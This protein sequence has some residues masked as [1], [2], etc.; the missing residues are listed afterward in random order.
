MSAE[1]ELPAGM[2]PAE[3]IAATA[4]RQALPGEAERPDPDPEAA[5][6]R[7]RLTEK[8]TVMQ[9]DLGGLFYE[10]AIRDALDMDVLLGKAA[11]LQQVDTEL[12]QLERAIRLQ[13]EGAGGTCENCGALHARSSS[14][15][16]VCGNALRVQGGVA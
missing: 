5:A 10:M 13:Q 8:L 2:V 16:S 7:H 6:R 15:C 14:F 4:R 11:E 3:K 1:A 9:A 12:G